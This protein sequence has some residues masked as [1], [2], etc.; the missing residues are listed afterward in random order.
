MATDVDLQPPAWMDGTTVPAAELRR[1]LLGLVVPQEGIIRGMVVQALPTP[2]MRVRVSG[3]GMAALSDGAGGYYPADLLADADLDVAS[4]SSTLNRRDAVIISMNDTGTAAGN[5]YRLR[6]ITGTAA[7]SPS[8]PTLPPADEPDAT[9]LLIG[10]VY[11]RAG[12]ETD[13][14]IRNQ[15]I[16]NPAP[17]ALLG[18]GEW[19]P[20]DLASGLQQAP[21]DDAPGWRFL[22]P[23]MVQVRGTLERT[24]GQPITTGTI[25][26]TLPPEARPAS[27]VHFVSAGQSSGGERAARP[28]VRPDGTIRSFHSPYEPGW[29]GMRGILFEATGAA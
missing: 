1:Q 12:A 16:T 13:G 23:G 3:P 29:I 28:E 4:S 25:L 8:L 9:Y 6:I 22:L 18:A 10:D 11:V 7:A 19:H 27:L 24:D 2:D 15:D 5:A 20:L 21:Y 17:N 26:A 14:Y